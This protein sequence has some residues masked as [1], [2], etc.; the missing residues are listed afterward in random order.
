MSETT[1]RQDALISQLSADLRPVRRLASPWRR[2]ALWLAAGLWVGMLLSLFADLGALW[3]RLTSAADMWVSVLGAA[4]TCVLAGGAALQI[5][6]PGRSARWALLPLPALAVWV[7]A[8]TAGC[9]RMTPLAAT[10]P[11]PA[12]HPMACLE[13]LLLVSLPLAVLLTW[14]LVRACPLRPG[15]TAALAG[16]A[17]AGGAATLLTLVHPFDATSD[18]LGVHALAVLLVVVVMRLAGG[19]ALRVATSPGR[20]RAGWS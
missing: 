9:L 19:R 18:D 5:A 12:M 13:F 16:L 15:L 8:S 7:G 10:M 17:S 4:A 6:V 3:T 14:L 20:P 1:L 2:T 11:M